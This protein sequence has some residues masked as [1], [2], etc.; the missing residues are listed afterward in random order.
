[1]LY[2]LVRDCSKFYNLP[3]FRVNRP[4]VDGG[5]QTAAFGLDTPQFYMV[6]LAPDRY[7]NY[8]GCNWV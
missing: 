6:K 2:N 5:R 3:R 4:A 7:K 8:N 1:M